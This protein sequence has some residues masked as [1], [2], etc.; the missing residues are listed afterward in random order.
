MTSRLE[1]AIA[2]GVLPESIDVYKEIAFFGIDVVD[3]RY[4]LGYAADDSAIIGPHKNHIKIYFETL[5]EAVDA[6][7]PVLWAEIKDIEDRELYEKYCLDLV[8][9]IMVRPASLALEIKGLGIS[10][11]TELCEDW[12]EKYEQ[13][14]KALRIQRIKELCANGDRVPLPMPFDSVEY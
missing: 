14:L 11:Q 2:C 12:P 1:Q 3:K 13:Q 8:Y 7:I 4:W 10:I 5:D 9:E 6:L